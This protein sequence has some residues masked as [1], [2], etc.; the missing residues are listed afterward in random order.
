MNYISPNSECG[1]CYEIDT[2]I[3]PLIIMLRRDLLIWEKR[4]IMIKKFVLCIELYHY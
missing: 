4:G 2:L 3:F 1:T